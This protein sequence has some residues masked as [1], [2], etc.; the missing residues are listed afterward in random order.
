[1]KIILIG[2]IS[3]ILHIFFGTIIAYIIHCTL[4]SYKIKKVYKNKDVKHDNK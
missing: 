3:V 2:F 4:W 1:M